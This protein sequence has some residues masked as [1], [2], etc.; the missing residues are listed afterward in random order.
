VKIRDSRRWQAVSSL[1]ITSRKSASFCRTLLVAFTNSGKWDRK[2]DSQ[3]FRSKEDQ[4]YFLTMSWVRSYKPTA[5]LESIICGC[6]LW[7]IHGA[8]GKETT[9]RNRSPT[10]GADCIQQVGQH[11]KSTQVCST[12][13]YSI[14]SE[15]RAYD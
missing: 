1:N 6:T 11:S 5:R 3:H 15:I 4:Y 10:L 2:W 12:F 9:S 14:L 13:E 7:K 8:E